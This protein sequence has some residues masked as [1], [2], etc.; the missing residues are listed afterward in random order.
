MRSLA[1]ALVLLAACSAR[2][3]EGLAPASQAVG[4]ERVA[5]FG[6]SLSLEGG[7]LER[8]LWAGGSV[9]AGFEHEAF[10]LRLRAPLQ[11]RVLDLAPESPRPPGFCAVVRCEAF[12]VHEEGFE[13]EGISRVVE[14]LRLGRPE[15]AVY[16]RGGPLLATLG[17]G[18]LIERYLN[19]PDPDRPQ[20][21]LLLVAR[22]PWL[23]LSLEGLVGN[24]LVPQKLSAL[25]LEARPLRLLSFLDEE[26]PMAR[27][28]GRL[29]LSLEGAGDLVVPVSPYGARPP[30]A[31]A[32]PLLGSALE[33]AWP[34]LDE[35]GWL[36]LAPFAAGSLLYGLSSTGDVTG[37]LGVGASAGGRAELRVP[38][39][40]LRVD[41]EVV[42]DSPAHRTGVFGLLYDIE[43]KHALA[44]AVVDGGG[45]AR[46]PARGGLG[47]AL[48][49]EAVVAS[50][51]RLGVRYRRDTAD[52][53]STGEAFAEVALFSFRAG[54]HAVRRDLERLEDALA[55]D[56][57]T[58]LVVEGAWGFFGPLSAFARY[59]RA[60]RFAD[61]KLR[62]DD[63]VQVGVSL[64]LV[65]AP[66]EGG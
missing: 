24:L 12:G 38:Y 55:W 65:L 5:G 62:V 11:L 66:P 50:A 35:G 6:L 45:I 43:R 47:F 33:V 21:G 64:D 16:A 41:G 51:L 15:E 60:P 48:G 63:D 44:G 42:A 25:R 32:R 31:R 28:F 57:R 53:G 27:L 20:S 13:V 49:A 23:G 4:R 40:G 29:A 8:D 17:S 2:A 61:G 39:L 46:V 34:L 30:L 37:E 3:D 59:Q 26:D 19:S 1:V 9:G 36:Q 58:L 10:A 22:L 7:L 14:E 54:A 56:E 18:R 52:G